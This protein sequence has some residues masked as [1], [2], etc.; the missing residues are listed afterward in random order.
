MS[1]GS[2]LIDTSV[3]IAFESGR[4]VEL[5]KLPEHPFVSVVTVGELL[6]GVHAAEDTDSRA[7]RLST[8]ETI[9]GATLLQVDSNAAAHWGRLRQR[10]R[11]NNRRAN[12]N[13]LWI[14][15]T[16]LAHSLP[17]ITQDA[18]FEILADLGGPQV[19]RV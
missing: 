11:E 15:A 10:L 9:A 6:A 14:A 19:I 7:A 13:D 3:F 5:E 12:I 16:A 4:H 17:V 2:G 8:V 18:D 1:V